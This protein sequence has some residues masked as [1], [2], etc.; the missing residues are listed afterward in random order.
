MSSNWKIFFLSSLGIS[1][2]SF[3]STYFCN[4]IILFL[5]TS[6]GNTFST[7]PRLLT[8]TWTENLSHYWA[9]LSTQKSIS[10]QSLM[11]GT[12]DTLIAQEGDWSNWRAHLNTVFIA[13]SFVS[14]TA[15]RNF[16]TVIL[17]TSWARKQH[18]HFQDGGTWKHTRMQLNVW[19]MWFILLWPQSR[20]TGGRNILERKTIPFHWTRFG[21]EDDFFSVTGPE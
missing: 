18:Y 2:R 11:V 20:M 1:P 15:L 7:F 17:T 6:A 19:S 3:C 16:C 12:F 14:G 8:A 4:S 5:L 10:M 9:L 21:H 13:H